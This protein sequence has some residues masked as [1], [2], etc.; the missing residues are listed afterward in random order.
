MTTVAVFGAGG[1]MGTRVTNRLK[2]MPGYNLLSVEEGEQGQRRLQ[3]RGLP[4][5]PAEEAARQADVVVLAIPDT[6]IG[7]VAEQVVP[8][9]RSGA[10]VM[11]LDPAAAYAGKL[12]RRDDIGYFITHPAHPP[13][14]NDEAEPGARHDHFG[15]IAKEAIVSALPQGT[16]EQWALGEQ[17]SRDIFGPILRS[18]RVTVEQMAILEPVLSETVA[19]T[20]LSI[21]RE[22]MDE[23]VRRGVPAEA[24]R[25]FLLGHINIELAI[26]F[27]MVDWDFSAGAKRAI[28]EAK[29]LLF[30][31]NW[32]RVFEPESLQE[33]VQQIT[34]GAGRAPSMTK[35]GS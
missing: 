6:L 18:H 28:E 23:A 33:S 31:E 22:A 35:S 30:K 5:T 32:K 24:A 8:K 16:E 2:G 17:I 12:P 14:F 19:A 7:P 29:P 15:G 10:L 34:G 27:N 4:A 20:A 11:L 26:L 1:N 25:D 13:V 9:L 21:V 3:E